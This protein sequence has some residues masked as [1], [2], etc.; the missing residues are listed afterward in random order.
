MRRIIFAHERKPR[1]LS[2]FDI[3]VLLKHH[4]R[5]YALGG[6]GSISGGMSNWPCRAH[7]MSAVEARTRR[8]YCFERYG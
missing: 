6:M 4:I 7:K 3:P 8:K 1:V 5:K 2:I